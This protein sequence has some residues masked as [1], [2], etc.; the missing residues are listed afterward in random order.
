MAG[1]LLRLPGGCV[2]RGWRRQRSADS[3]PASR[4]WTQRCLQRRRP[5]LFPDAGNG[6]NYWVDVVFEQPDTV[7]PTITGR[8]PADGATGVGTNTNVVVTF[9]E[10]VAP[11]SVTSSS[12]RLRA[13]G[14]GSDVTAALSVAGATVVLDPSGDLAPYTSYTATVTTAVTD[15]FGN[16]LATRPRP[17][18]SRPAGS[19]RASSTRPSATLASGR[20]VRTPTC[21]TPP[22]AKLILAPT[23]G[24]EFD[25]S[26]LPSDW[27]STAPWSW[28]TADH[29]AGG[30][31]ERRRAWLPL[32]RR[33]VRPGPLARVRGDVRR[34][35]RSSTSASSSTSTVP[36]AAFG[37][38]SAP[39]AAP[40]TGVFARTS[41]IRQLPGSRS[42]LSACATSLPDRLD[43]DQDSCSTSMA[44]LR[45]DGDRRSPRP[46]RP[47]GQRLRARRRRLVVDWI[48]MTPFASPG[49]FESRVLDA[50]TT[51]DWT[52]LTAITTLPADTSASFETRT[53]NTTDPN[54]RSWSAW[55]AVAGDV[56][57]S[58][59]ARYAQYRV[60]LATSVPGPDAGRRARR[61]DGS[62][63]AG[64]R[65]AGR[66]RR[67]GH[68]DRGHR[69]RAAGQRR[70]LAGRQ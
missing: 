39:R 36:S 47:I 34:G 16:P 45:S 21:P 13:D 70:R 57:A 33:S 5:G 23:V 8:A 14:A 20:P 64:Q 7:A 6:A 62:E 15:R 68:R 63:P 43:R 3:A 2:H 32:G 61:A 22:A 53:G 38:R 29:V 9:S 60:T 65:R 44:A 56:I 25:G 1:R 26:S 30:S 40:A 35:A 42:A 31:L 46:M 11:G 10:P 69:A 27:T 41:A 12:V 59:N 50:G 19:P 48:R 17:G 66:R 28:R 4:G 52:S 49:T 54:D 55:Q 24:A 67:H 58:P 37:D 51:H 18:R